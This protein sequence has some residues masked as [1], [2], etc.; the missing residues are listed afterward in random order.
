MPLDNGKFASSDLNDLN[1]GVINRNNRTRRLLELRA[2]PVILISEAAMLQRSVDALVDNGLR[3]RPVMFEG[4]RLHS[5][6]DMVGGSRGRF[7]HNLT[8]K[9]VDYSAIA[10]C[11][12]VTLLCPTTGHA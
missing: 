3:D 10:H 12:V 2:P 9:R 7:M 11:R 4:R 6:V 5:L 8:G 1:R